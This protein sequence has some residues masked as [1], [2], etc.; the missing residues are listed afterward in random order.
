MKAI[1]L[2][3][4][5]SV[6][7]IAIAQNTTSPDADIVV[8]GKKADQAR[9]VRDFVRALNG[10]SGPNPLAKFD[11]TE[12]CPIAIGLGDVHDRAIAQ[13]M[14]RI[15][16]AAAIPIAP[17]G[18]RTNALVIFADDKDAMI[19]ALRKAHPAY[20]RT[21]IGSTITVPRQKGPVTAWHLSARLDRYGVQIPSEGEEPGQF[22][23]VPDGA[24]RLEA[25]VRPVFVA[26]V[27]V[28]ER[29][30]VDGLTTTQI[31]DYAAMRSFAEIDPGRLKPG[32][33]PTILTIMD[34]SMD[35]EVPITMT[36]WDLGYLRALYAVRPLRS[37][38]SQRA[39]M[40]KRINH[41]L[42]ASSR[43]SDTDSKTDAA[44]PH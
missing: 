37:A 25:N 7:S 11:R 21:G 29:K 12:L 2:A 8:T 32:Q 4:M 3:A 30:A 36:P 10:L 19:D 38:M 33:A 20:F 16:T 14:R 26:S 1:V 43:G 18:C 22:V 39:E 13:R 15:A 6:T 41:D 23:S 5:F 44:Q 17:E 31:G 42:D 35:S 24:S 40:G 34:S 28:I 9:Q 27:V